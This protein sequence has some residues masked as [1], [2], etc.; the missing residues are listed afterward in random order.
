[1]RRPSLIDLQP[2]LLNANPTT[3]DDLPLPRLGNANNNDAPGVTMPYEPPRRRCLAHDKPYDSLT[4]RAIMAACATSV[5]LL[6]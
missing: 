5:A 2:L 6:A 1:M 3:G 4:N